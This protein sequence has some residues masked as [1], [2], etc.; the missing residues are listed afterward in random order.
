MSPALETAIALGIVL[1]C[2]LYL[3]RSSFILARRLFS[4]R[5]GGASCGG[6]GGG[7]GDAAPE[8]NPGAGQT[9]RV[10]LVKL[11]RASDR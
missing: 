4:S 10:E 2:A 11:P 7:C 6:C 9:K 8:G 5:P 3:A 1:A